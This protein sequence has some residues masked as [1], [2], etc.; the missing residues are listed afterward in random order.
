MIFTSPL[1]T[2]YYPAAPLHAAF[3]LADEGVMPLHQSVKLISQNAAA[4]MGL[5]DRGRIA[6]GSSADLV[7]VENDGFH[8]VRGTIRRGVPIFRDSHLAKLAQVSALLKA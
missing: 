8:R 3:R 7:L 2:D 5:H 1:A 6:P 4:A